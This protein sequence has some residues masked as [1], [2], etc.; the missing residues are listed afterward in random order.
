MILLLLRP[1]ETYKIKNQSN[2]LHQ[3]FLEGIKYKNNF[4]L[5][6]LFV[7]LSHMEYCL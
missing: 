4:F 5:S 1:T 3:Y 6:A 2:L 7:M